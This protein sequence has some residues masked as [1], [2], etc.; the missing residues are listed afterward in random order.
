MNI[1]KKLNFGCGTRIEKGWVNLDIVNHKGVDVVHDLNKFPYPFKD[2]Y[3]EVINARF[4]LEHLDKL[5]E[6]MNELC[7]ILKPGGKLLIKV[8]YQTCIHTLASYQH[9]RAF[10]LRTFDGYAKKT[11]QKYGLN[12][13]NDE[14][15]VGF[16]FLTIKRRLDFPRGLH[17][18]SY[19]VEPLANFLPKIYEETFLRY[20][21]PAFSISIELVK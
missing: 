6:T 15:G 11:N 18:E 3:F 5:D 4:V 9:K 14:Y 10:T 8:P 19:I 13:R 1:I 2:N 17:I 12:V 21:L 7:R 16:V 20:L